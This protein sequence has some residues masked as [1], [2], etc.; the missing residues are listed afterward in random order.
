MACALLCSFWNQSLPPHH[1]LP[2]DVYVLKPVALIS[3]SSPDSISCL[4]L[5]PSIISSS[6]PDSSILSSL[7]LESILMIEGARWRRLVPADLVR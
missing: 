5:D 2:I 6:L 4:S 1:H 3:A 7:L